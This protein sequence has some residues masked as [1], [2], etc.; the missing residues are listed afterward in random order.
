MIHIAICDDEMIFRDKM[1]EHIV[2]YLTTLQIEFVVDTFSSGIDF[3][4]KDT[5]MLNYHIVFLD[6]NMDVLDGVQ[7][8]KRVRKV[9]KEMIIVFVTAF[10]SYSL[11]VYKVGAIRYLLKNNKNFAN[12]INECMDSILEE[13]NYNI[14]KRSFQF[15]EG[16]KQV[17]LE[18]IIYI[19]SKLH[20][21]E[22]HIMEE[23]VVVYSL[24]EKLNNMEKV[25]AGYGFIRIHQ[26]YL[27]N[28]KYLKKV[29]SYKAVLYNEMVF[30]IPKTRYKFVKENFLA[31]KGRV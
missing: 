21:L 8:A 4:S 10:I 23:D 31:Y 15:K 7:T 3:I 30:T 2:K 20:K 11:E 22:F 29:T 5:E 27:L 1:R 28:L 19:E 12:A 9:S 26:S 25:L 18:R 24:Y 13:M 6:I 17:S 16:T 14:A